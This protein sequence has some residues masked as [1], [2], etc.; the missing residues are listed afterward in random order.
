MMIGDDDEY[1]A[2]RATVWRQLIDFPER[3]LDTLVLVCAEY[4]IDVSKDYV[5]STRARWRN[6]LE[7]LKSAG[8]TVP[9]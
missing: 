9:G 4:G 7:V 3:D 1:L 2:R 8:L 5:R 6:T